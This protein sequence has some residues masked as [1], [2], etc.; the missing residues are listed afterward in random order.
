MQS[1]FCNHPSISFEIAGSMRGLLM[2]NQI[3][4]CYNNSPVT[5]LAKNN[6]QKDT[7]VVKTNN[8][9]E[10]EY[11]SSNNFK[12]ALALTQE[13][14]IKQIGHRA[15]VINNGIKYAHIMTTQITLFLKKKTPKYYQKWNSSAKYYV[16]HPQT[17]KVLHATGE[18][19]GT[20]ISI[21]E[22]DKAR[23]SLAASAV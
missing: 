8:N 12:Q 10:S 6:T 21:A 5:L 15:W 1:W 20:R 16:C 4:I 13:C 2:Q 14:A 23:S 9:K 11:A 7:Y 3:Q 22:W 18:C 17:G 19:A